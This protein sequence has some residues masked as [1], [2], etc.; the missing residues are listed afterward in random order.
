VP[1][2]HPSPLQARQQNGI[3]RHGSSVMV[4]ASWFERHGSNVMDRTI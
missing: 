3:E 2:N 1:G 4:R